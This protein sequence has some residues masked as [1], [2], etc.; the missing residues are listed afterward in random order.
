MTNSQNILSDKITTVT[1]TDVKLSTPCIVID[2]E[3]AAYRR[4]MKLMSQ[5]EQDK[6][7]PKQQVKVN[8]SHPIIQ[9]MNKIRNEDADLAKDIAEQIFDNALMQAGLLDDG[10]SMV[11]RLNKILERA[12]QRKTNGTEEEPEP[13]N[14]EEVSTEKTKSE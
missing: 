8:T 7:L 1:E 13:K 6:Q 4:M 3:G 12:F 10:R 14:V 11:P 9:H 2:P 5:S